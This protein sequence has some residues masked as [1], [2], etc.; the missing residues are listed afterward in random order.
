VGP[1]SKFHNLPYAPFGRSDRLG[2]VADFTQPGFGS[3][4]QQQQMQQQRGRQSYFDQRNR[5]SSG[6]DNNEGFQYR[7]DPNEDNFLLVDTTKSSSSQKKFVLPAS[8]RRQQRAS[9]LRQL[10][11]RRNAAGAAMDSTRF[12]P[13]SSAYARRRGGAHAA[14]QWGRGGGGPMGGRGARTGWR[15]RMDRQASVSVKADWV[16]LDEFELNKLAKLKL[17]GTMPKEKD[18]LWCGF[19]DQYNEAYD[20]ISTKNS[21]PLKRFET[22][23][24]YPVS[25]TD[26]PVIE[27]LAIEGSAR[28]FITDA[29]LSH[30]MV[31]PRSIF[32]WDIIVQKLPDGTL[33]FDKRDNSQFDF[34]TVSETALVLPPTQKSEEDPEGVNTLEKLSL[35]A[36][37]I[38]QNFSQQIL[39]K[40]T[41]QQTRKN[42][43]LPNPFFDEEDAEGMEPASVG[44]RYRKFT[45]ADGTE[46]ICRCELH[47][48]LLSKGGGSTNTSGS[49]KPSSATSLNTAEAEYLTAFAL[50]E[51]DPK[52]VPG[53]MN[54]RDKIDTQRGAVLAT[55][56][57]N[58][59]CKL[60]KWTALSIL[61]GANQMKIGFV[62]RASRNNNYEHVILAT[63]FYTPM[64]FATQITL[65]VPNMWGI[66][67][68]FVDRFSSLPEGKYVFL[69]D[70]NKPVVRLY[71]VP[72]GT[73]EEEEDA[74]DEEEE[75][76]GGG[77]NEEDETAP[78]ETEA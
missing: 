53:A 1:K 27:K 51:W 68:K 41:S 49:S 48:F 73:F 47:G 40:H 10:N 6:A 45:F 77:D 60:A 8:K 76:R 26:D 22:K 13:R 50:H 24:F 23:E 64:E 39:K 4:A 75:Q 3:A 32:S 20:K 55:E 12:H 66:F 18:V 78:M 15:D 2:K 5:W 17:E 43:D 71:S 59:A 31:C 57:K 42:F 30:L 37:S 74:D 29:I 46:L 35:E 33:F 56:L 19:V 67:K 16:V 25:T 11:A 21:V 70:P 38:N 14:P 36:T 52:S 61:A 62:S 9:S 28:V 58:N 54:W 34:L 7:V 65:S 72:P 69:R 63:Q 44:Y